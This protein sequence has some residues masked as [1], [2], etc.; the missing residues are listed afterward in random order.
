M[1]KG[2]DKWED[3]RNVVFSYISLIEMIESGSKT[4]GKIK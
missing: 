4:D 3:R 2:I 1:R